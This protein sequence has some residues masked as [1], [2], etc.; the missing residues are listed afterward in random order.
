MAGDGPG[1]GFLRYIKQKTV[2]LC[3]PS[4]PLRP[5]RVIGNLHAGRRVRPTYTAHSTPPACAAAVPQPARPPRELLP[6]ELVNFIDLGLMNFT[7][8]GPKLQGLA[9]GADDLTTW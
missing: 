4:H 2:Q 1:V 7:L 3:D 6:Y 8:T 5:G 9:D